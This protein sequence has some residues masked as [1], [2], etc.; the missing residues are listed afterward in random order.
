MTTSD[1]SR[2][3]PLDAATPT[4][5]AGLGRA[6][7]PAT[8][9]PDHIAGLDG[10]RALAVCAVVVFHLWPW[11]LPG[12]FL[13]VTV[14]FA[15]SGYLITTL[16]L[17]EI[18]RTGRVDLRRFVQRRV[19]RLLPAA[20]ATV[21]VIAVV[22]LVAGW[23][24]PTTGRELVAAS[25]QVSNWQRIVDGQQYGIDAS[26]SPVLH[27]WSLAIEE[28]IYLVLPLLILVART[29][30]RV[31]A[32]FLVAMGASVA[33]TV[34]N[35]GQATVVYYSTFS[36]AAEVLAGALVAVWAYGRV[37]SRRPAAPVVAGAVA[38]LGGGVLFV[39]VVF[40][41]LGDDWYYRGGLTVIGVTAAVSI[42]ALCR[43]PLLARLVDRR[44]LRWVGHRS[45]GIYLFHWPVLVGLTTA[46]VAA[47]WVPWL[48]IVITA[49]ITA[50]SYASYEQPIRVGAVGG[51]RLAGLLVGLALITPATVVAGLGRQSPQLDVAQ[52]QTELDRLDL[53][54]RPAVDP[55]VGGASAEPAVIESSGV[56]LGGGPALS[57]S[58]AVADA[59]TADGGV[60]DAHV[61]AVGHDD[62]PPA[63]PSTDP[64][65]LVTSPADAPAPVDP[66]LGRAGAVSPIRVGF[67][68]DSKA[69][70]LLVGLAT[71]ADERFGY[72]HIDAELGCPLVRAD[73]RRDDR[74]HPRVEVWEHCDWASRLAGVD[75]DDQI[76]LAL[77]WSGSWDLVELRS[78]QF[79]DRWL[80]ILDDEFREWM[81][82]EM[83]AFVE[84]I[85][86][87]TSATR[88]LWMNL[89][90]TVSTHP[91]RVDAYNGLLADLADANPM[92]EVVD[93]AGWLAV[94]SDADRLLPDGV[95]PSWGTD[96]G[97]N[98]AAEIGE[99]WLYELL[100]ASADQ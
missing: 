62:G 36:R 13:G 55:A 80:T 97:A 75:P 20:L 57:R 17:G 16:L 35:A 19:R 30:R 15:L 78:A 82:T 29:R 31:A 48:T 10:L 70:A 63:D 71:A 98:S 24:S 59:A 86:A 99:L 64:I 95:H 8:N 79:G 84:A 88:V 92:V 41:S 28:Q 83:E 54:A 100:V 44:L 11:V 21:A 42:G 93:I 37:S 65:E 9:L 76:D 74:H 32:V 73:W 67:F 5:P 90:D 96:G 87:A 6:S 18:E 68:G 46:G 3:A 51:R 27:F 39:A 33:Y 66:G 89:P 49:A 77:V 91:G 26:A 2:S 38:V 34:A 94:R 52:L 12:G 58:P 14:F 47:T 50:V 45:Y 85:V 25:L 60:R 81:A 53:L 22:W 23:S 1:H 7:T 56:S 40:T 69:V 4:I 72:V 61:R 43:T